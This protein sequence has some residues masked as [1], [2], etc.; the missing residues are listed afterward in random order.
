[1]TYTTGEIPAKGDHVRF[2]N[3]AHHTHPEASESWIV[4]TVCQDMI[5][6]KCLD[7]TAWRQA[8]FT[9]Q[10]RLIERAST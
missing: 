1:M 3:E 7:K 4:M 5:R 8:F 2:E 10:M 9:A 6:A